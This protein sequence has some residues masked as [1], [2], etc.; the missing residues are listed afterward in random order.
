MSFDRTVQAV[1]PVL[2]PLLFVLVLI[3]VF[4]HI[5]LFLPTLWYR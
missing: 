1:L 2:V 4:P 5:T 3:S